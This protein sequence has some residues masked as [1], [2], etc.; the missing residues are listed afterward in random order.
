MTIP[1]CPDTCQSPLP[2]KYLE[3][4]PEKAHDKYV[5]CETV[6]ADITESEMAATPTPQQ[7]LL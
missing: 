1:I 5:Y 6:L 7:L 2:Y 4:P 3:F